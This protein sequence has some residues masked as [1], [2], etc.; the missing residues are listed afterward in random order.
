MSRSVFD[1][2]VIVA[3]TPPRRLQ[4][5]EFSHVRLFHGCRPTSVDSYYA[6]GIRVVSSAE[7]AN[8]FREIYAD[9]PSAAVETAIASCP[10][11]DCEERV[12][13]A[14]DLRFLVKHASHYLVQGS[15]TLKAWGRALPRLHGAD[16][17]ARL[18]SI[19]RPTAFLVDAPLQTVDNQDVK[20]LQMKLDLLA[21]QGPAA[22]CDDGDLI[23]F[24]TSYVSGVPREWLVGH[25]FIDEATD[26]DD[27]GA[28]Y[29]YVDRS[30]DQ[31]GSPG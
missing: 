9:L 29:R 21:E 26:P 4:L 28:R 7:L 13:L 19:G 18:K 25:Q 12:D 3:E 31:P 15:E 10:R 11:T 23:D 14:L 16:P 24:A 20:D 6:D 22:A 8:R 5:S 30:S 2:A 1:W 17:T 27:R